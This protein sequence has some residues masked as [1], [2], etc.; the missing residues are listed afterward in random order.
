MRIITC[1]DMNCDYNEK[2]VCYSIEACEDQIQTYK[3]LCEKYNLQC[4]QWC[5]DFN[6][7]DNTNEISVV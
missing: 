3:K 7:C 6:C 5:E 4:C 1:Y 2:N